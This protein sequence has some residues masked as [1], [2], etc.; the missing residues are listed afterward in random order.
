LF[1]LSFFHTYFGPISKKKPCFALG[2][3]IHIFTMKFIL[4]VLYCCL[5]FGLSAQSDFFPEEYVVKASTLN[6]REKPDKNSKKLA[7][8]P[9]GTLVQFQEVWNMGEWL[10]ADS[11]DE[12]APWGQWIKVKH[13]KNSGWVFSAYIEPA[14]S[15]LYEDE[16]VYQEGMSI[17][18]LH[19]YGV[20]ARD[21]FADEIRRVTIKYELE[22]NE[23]YGGNVKSI[24][25]NQ[26]DKSKFLIGSHK[27]LSTGYCGGL[28]S[29]DMTSAFYTES[30]YPGSLLSIYPG[31]DLADT[32]IKP[33][34]G[35]AATGCAS[36]DSNSMISVKDYKL[37][38]LDWSANQPFPTQ[39]LTQWVKTA[40][41][42]I[43]PMVS[44]MWF[45][46]IDRDNK[47]DALI[48]DC[49]YE[50]GCRV[51]LFLSSKARTSEMLRKVTE[52]FFPM[53]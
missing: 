14:I 38:L 26:P 7:T 49:P 45:G 27:P 18:P 51:S 35:L 33:S 31:N 15:L 39:D 10:S 20:Y 4:A 52:H 36:L 11:T 22:N 40:M 43:N 28:G 46:D 21:S 29:F 23:I 19:W 48:S 2:T 42:E 17:A 32:L 47:P 41:P 25:T 53:D 50:M 5:A 34:Y 16:F 6:M 13:E 30:L 12:Q 24:K 9:N 8:L 3:Y 1:C 37:T 44:L